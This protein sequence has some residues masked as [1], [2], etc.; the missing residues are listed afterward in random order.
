MRG[1]FFGLARGADFFGAAT[2]RVALPRDGA[3]F[4]FV[5]AGAVRFLPAFFVILSSGF[6]FFFG[7]KSGRFG[8]A[9]SRE[10][11]RRECVF[12]PEII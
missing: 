3:V 5:A 10:K 4:R 2:L 6:F 8:G 7:I 12:Y 11:G 9:E 1:A